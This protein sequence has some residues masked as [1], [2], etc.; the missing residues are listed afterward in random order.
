MELPRT[1][2]GGPRAAP[3]GSEA[4]FTW[5]GCRNRDA[6]RKPLE[7]SL[8]AFGEAKGSFWDALGELLASKS[9]SRVSETLENIENVHFYI[10]KLTI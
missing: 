9:S 1:L 3:R 10:I 6:A 4:H 7:R 5:K 2:I 8:G